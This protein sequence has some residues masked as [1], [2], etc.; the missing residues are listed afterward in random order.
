VGFSPPDYFEERRKTKKD[1]YNMI[2]DNGKAG[3]ED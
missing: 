1:D 3:G 2:I